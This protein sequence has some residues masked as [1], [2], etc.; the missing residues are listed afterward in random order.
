MGTCGDLGLGGFTRVY[1][2][3]LRSVRIYF[4]EE[5][6][7]KEK[8]ERVFGAWPSSFGFSPLR[9]GG[10]GFAAVSAVV[11]GCG[12]ACAARFQFYHFS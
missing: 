8:R 4:L 2:D 7:R 1:I 10:W 6:R 12:A 5:E 3:S 9:F 11:S